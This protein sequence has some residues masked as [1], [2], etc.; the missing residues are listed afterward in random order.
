MF[1]L[2]IRAD[3]MAPTLMSLGTSVDIDSTAMA[4]ATPLAATPTQLAAMVFDSASLVSAQ[5]QDL[6]VN[7]S[8]TFTGTY[9]GA[10]GQFR[11]HR[12]MANGSCVIL[13]R[14]R[15]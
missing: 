11:V 2:S 13:A 12:A 14:L 15:R 4:G 1:A 6:N 10:P 9:F 3:G 5:D 7:M 8:E